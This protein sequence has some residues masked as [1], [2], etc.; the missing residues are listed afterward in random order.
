MQEVDNILRILEESRKAFMN[1]DSAQLKLISNQTNNT[2]SLTQDPENIAIAVI[3]YSLSKIIENGNNVSREYSKKIIDYLIQLKLS[4]QKS[5]KKN[6]RDILGKFNNY[7]QRD[8]LKY[9]IYVQDVFRKASINKASKLY[10]HGL[11]MEK[12]ANLLGVTLYEL[13]DY[14]GSKNLDI[15]DG[16]EISAKSRIKIAEEVFR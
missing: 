8:S 2:A 10:E 11:S 16:G 12:T 6:V 3:I 7:I 4:L 14:I 9:K 15:K 1:N 5:D 13:S